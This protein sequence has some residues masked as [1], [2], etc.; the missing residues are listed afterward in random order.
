MFQSVL[1]HKHDGIYLYQG[2]KYQISESFLYTKNIWKISSEMKAYEGGIN[3][4]LDD[5][6]EKPSKIHMDN[7]IRTVL[8]GYHK[9]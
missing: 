5:I 4:L 2:I 6:R 9:Q 1:R 3:K 7:S 8:T